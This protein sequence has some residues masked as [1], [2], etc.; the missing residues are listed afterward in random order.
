MPGDISNG[1]VAKVLESLKN[2]AG[3][4]DSVIFDKLN[5]YQ[6]DFMLNIRTSQKTIPIAL[7][8][9]TYEYLRPERIFTI[10]K[11]SN[12]EDN[13]NEYSGDY[14]PEKDSIII[15]DKY[16]IVSGDKILVTG[17][18]RPIYVSMARDSGGGKLNDRI[19]KTVD[20]II[21]E[22]YHDYLVE[23]VLSE[24]RKV[25]P[26][27]RKYEDIKKDVKRTSYSLLRTN[28]FGV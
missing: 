23:A 4:V 11:I 13:E 10:L 27:F 9:G 19:S 6:L 21:E 17:F 15:E 3:P 7:V 24:Y 16:S 28:R 18:V 25:N 26:E 20:P 8:T 12:S 22:D 2:Y 14:S 1:L 5:K